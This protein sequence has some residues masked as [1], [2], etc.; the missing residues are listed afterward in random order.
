MIHYAAIG[1][2]LT[3]GVGDLFG[4]GFVPKYGRMIEDRLGQ[5]VVY[6]KMG[7][8]G[9]TTE[10]ILSAVQCDHRMRAFIQNADIITLTAGGND[11]LDAAKAYATSKNAD[12]FRQALTECRQNLAGI[13]GV[14]RK[15]KHGRAPYLIRAVDLYNPSP[16]LPE[17]NVWIKRFN[18]QLESFQ[19]GNLRV[20]NIFDSFQGRQR[21]LLSLDHFH[22][23]GRGYAVI[24]DALDRQGYRPLA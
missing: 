18:S 20:A 16:S 8:N 15:L 23:N 13:F 1:D 17:A 5:H 10:N 2:S 3:S 19:D 6:E 21:E 24:A 11:L 14:I 7:I 12:L 22:P 4:G 9:A